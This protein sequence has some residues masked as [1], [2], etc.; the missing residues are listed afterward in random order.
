MQGICRLL[1][2]IFVAALAGFFGGFFGVKTPQSLVE[3]I[4]QHEYIEESEF[5]FANEKIA[6]AVVSIIASKDLIVFPF[7]D[8]A[9]QHE[10]FLGY[11]SQEISGGTGFI[12]S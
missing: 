6:P 9:S 11:K 3:V 5:V 10:S 1:I 4:E 7:I 12:V 8:P 2:L